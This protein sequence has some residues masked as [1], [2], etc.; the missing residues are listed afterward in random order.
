MNL[1]NSL[2]ATINH[3]STQM[4]GTNTRVGSARKARDNSLNHLTSVPSGLKDL[5]ITI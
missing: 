2:Q 4:S 3:K 1:A 5:A